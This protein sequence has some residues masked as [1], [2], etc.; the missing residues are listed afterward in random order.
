M[1]STSVPRVSAATASSNHPAMERG[2]IPQR[3]S[4]SLRITPPRCPTPSETL[5][6]KFRPF[7]KRSL[8]LR[9]STSWS[10]DFDFPTLTDD[11]PCVKVIVVHV[12]WPYFKSTDPDILSEEASYASRILQDT[13]PVGYSPP[14]QHVDAAV[15]CVGGAG[16]EAA[17]LEIEYGHQILVR[18]LDQG[19]RS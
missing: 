12:Q 4:Q 17:P 18:G 15:N 2:V 16:V 9:F 5:L 10:L 19:A 14:T 11:P 6:Q 7:S 8:D 1:I 13:R 3:H